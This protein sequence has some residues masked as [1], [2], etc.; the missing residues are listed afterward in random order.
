MGRRL[1]E[2]IGVLVVAFDDGTLCGGTKIIVTH[3]GGNVISASDAGEVLD[4]AWRKGAVAVVLKNCLR[5]VAIGR[6][7]FPVM[8]TRNFEVCGNA[9]LISL[10]GRVFGK[11]ADED[12]EPDLEDR[13][14][15]RL[16]LASANGFELS[17]SPASAGGD[18]FI[19]DSLLVV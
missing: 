8:K 1:E 13:G 12:E 6:V 17:Y 18:L 19:V 16:P 15:R 7:E 10:A 14:G 5:I 2:V 11:A 9:E 3:V 4:D